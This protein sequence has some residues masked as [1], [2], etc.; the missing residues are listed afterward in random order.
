MGRFDLMMNYL[1]SIESIIMAEQLSG[2]IKEEA[3]LFK[4]KLYGGK[5]VTELFYSKEAGV[6]RF[7]VRSYHCEINDVVYDERRELFKKIKREIE[8]CDVDYDSEDDIITLNFIEDQ[9]VIEN[10]NR[11]LKML[12]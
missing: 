6:T 1:N 8:N 5:Y 7:A 12:I 9:V 11:A 4:Y 10:I 2:N 3:T